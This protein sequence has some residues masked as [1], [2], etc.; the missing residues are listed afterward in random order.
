MLNKGTLNQAI[1]AQKKKLLAQACPDKGADF[2]ERNL[3][4][5][6]RQDGTELYQY[7]GKEILE[8][9]PP[10]VKCVQEGD[11][12]TISATHKFRILAP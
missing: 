12:F 4:V 1:A 10:E 7:A 3:A 5:F 6:M 11:S 8:I 9:S 2:K